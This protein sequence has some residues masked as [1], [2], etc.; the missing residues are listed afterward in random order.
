M[1]SWDSM[2]YG[3]AFQ[4]K[5]ARCPQTQDK[6]GAGRHGV[7]TLNTT[8]QAHKLRTQALWKMGGLQ[9]DYIPLYL[10]KRMQSGQLRVQ[11]TG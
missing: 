5:A 3:K 1:V 2:N 10:A 9:E 4:I 7:T 6:G 11:V 8:P